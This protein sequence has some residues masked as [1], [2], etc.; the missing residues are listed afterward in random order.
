ML[1]IKED[2]REECGKLGEV[3]NVVLYDKEPDGVSSVRYSTPESARAC[4]R[5]SRSFGV[6]PPLRCQK[7]FAIRKQE[8]P[9][10]PATFLSTVMAL[11]M[12]VTADSGH[13]IGSC[14]GR[15]VM[16]HKDLPGTVV[17]SSHTD[18]ICWQAFPFA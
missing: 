9:L 6:N 10:T 14:L 17:I 5:V 3:T 13:T 11:C 8:E 1:E 2:I 7:I 15:L 16:S 4:V 18:F 12:H